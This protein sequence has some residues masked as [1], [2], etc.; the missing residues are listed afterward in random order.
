MAIYHLSVK[1]IGRSE[2]RSATAAAAYRA[3]DKITDERTGEIH[4]YTRKGGVSY[5][6][7]LLPDN[8]PTWAT[9]RAELWNAAEQSE[10]RKNSTVAREFEIALPSELSETERQRLAVDF[11]KEIVERHKVAADVAIHEPS[12]GGDNKN[13]HAH[14]LITTRQL[15]EDGFTKKTRELDDRKSGEIDRWRERFAELQNERLKKNGVAETVDYRTLK[16]QGIDREP[17]KHLGVE[18]TNYERRTGNKSNKRLDFEQQAAERLKVATEIK[19]LEREKQQIQHTIINL[20]KEAQAEVKT[21]VESHN[22]QAADREARRQQQEQARQIEQ[23]KPSFGIEDKGTKLE[24]KLNSSS[25]AKDL[26]KTAQERGWDTIKI[27][28]TPEFSREVWMEAQIHGIETIG[29]EPTAIDTAA[30]RLAKMPA[31]PTA[32]PEK[33]KEMLEKLEQR[34]EQTLNDLELQLQKAWRNDE[35]KRLL[36]EAEEKR[37]AAWALKAKEP[38]SFFSPKKHDVWEVEMRHKID[39]HSRLKQEATK[40]IEGKSPNEPSFS[41][42]ARVVLKDKYPELAQ[43]LIDK[44]ARELLERE[45]KQREQ[46]KIREQKRQEQAQKSKQK[47]RDWDIDER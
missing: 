9:N 7:I 46:A 45:E 24:T 13:H 20:E 21:I 23:K 27:T 10:T 5:T 12:R 8:A 41:G 29:Y 39:D 19:Q 43:A 42:K 22:K 47:S 33:S 31:M 11:A 15:T 4:D 32:E 38:N 6:E 16:A 44:A 17:T 3:A 2:G 14:I 35:N 30:L 37:Q 28:G 25:A 40:A 34:A 18:A 1:T 36:D 26:I